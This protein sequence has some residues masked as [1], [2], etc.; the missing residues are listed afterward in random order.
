MQ[1]IKDIFQIVHL[2]NIRIVASQLIRKENIL[3]GIE[4]ITEKIDQNKDRFPSTFLPRKND[5]FKH[6][7]YCFLH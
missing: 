1:E 3:V 2:C 7:I 5:N 4:F 6:K